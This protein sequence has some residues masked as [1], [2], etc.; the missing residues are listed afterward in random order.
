M[1]RWI[2]VQV[3]TTGLPHQYAGTRIQRY[4]FWDSS[5]TM[6]MQAFISLLT[7]LT[8]MTAKMNCEGGFALTQISVFKEQDW[9]YQLFS[10]KLLC[11]TLIK[12]FSVITSQGKIRAID[13][14]VIEDS[15]LRYSIYQTLFTHKQ[16]SAHTIES[17]QPLQDILTI[18]IILLQV[19]HPV[20]IPD[21]YW[22]AFMT[23][24]YA[25]LDIFSSLDEQNLLACLY[26]RWKYDQMM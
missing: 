20:S 17:D 2:N 12:T 9:L 21:T 8:R 4:L 19:C 18:K 5:V 3:T 7:L 24:M 16:I 6:S 23:E 11:S 13:V 26:F 15:V 14:V 22:S 1:M 25:E 10:H